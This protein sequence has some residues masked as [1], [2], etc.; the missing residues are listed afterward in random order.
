MR[1]VVQRVKS[2]SVVVDNE[3]IGNIGNGLLVLL[4]VA[5]T[6]KSYDAEYLAEKIVNL[7]IFEDENSKMNRSL[8][9]IGGEMLVVS[10]FTLLGDCK[11]GRRPSFVNAAE[12]SVANELYEQ[13]VVKV[14]EKGV[15]VK[16]G[17]FRALMD[18]S[19]TNYG[20]VTLILESR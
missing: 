13:F 20:P 8:I 14:R 7:R 5:K 18:V 4:G 9:D 17:R 1:A 16:T 12:P 10:Q 3:I 19:L 6:D 15:S 11:K 2:S